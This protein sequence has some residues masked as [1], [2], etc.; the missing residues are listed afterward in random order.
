MVTYFSN[1][2]VYGSVKMLPQLVLGDIYD[3]ALNVY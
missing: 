3:H 1:H 2:Q